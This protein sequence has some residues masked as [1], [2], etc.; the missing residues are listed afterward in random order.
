MDYSITARELLDKLGGEKNIQSLT[1]CMTRLR[2]VL[3]D[4]SNIDDGAVGNIPGVIG[5]NRQGGQYQVIIGNNVAK[6]FREIN[7]IASSSEAADN[8]PKEKQNPVSVAIDFISGCMTQL[9]PAIIAGGMIKVLLII[10]G[11]TLLGL[12]ESTGDTYIILN[13]LGDAPFYFLPVMVAYTAS[14]KLNCNSFLSVTVAAMLLYPDLITLL[15]GDAPTYLFGVIPVTHASYS[16]SIIP[17]MLAVILLKY[18]EIGVDKITPDWSKNFLKPLLI[19]LI[20]GLVTIVALAPLGAIIGTGLQIVINA[21]YNFAPWIAMLLF[22]GAMPF[23]V[24][25]GMHW[26]FVPTALM[27]LADPGFELMLLP[28]MLC[29]NTAQ[30]GATFGVALKT[31]DK[32]MREMAI[33]AGI[34]ALLAGVTEP[35]MYGV[36]L[37]LKK[38]MIAACIASGIAGVITGIVN[39]KAFAFATPCLTAIVQFVAPDGGRN[40]VTAVVIY[41]ISFVLS[42]VLAFILT[43]KGEN[44]QTAGA[45][46]NVQAAEA[47]ENGQIAA[48]TSVR[49][50]VAATNGQSG[51]DVPAGKPL[52]VYN[53]LEGEVIPLAD[54]DD[55][56]FSSEVLG[57][58]YAV[59]PAVG[60]V[61]APF[62]G[63]VETL[64]DTHHALGL[65]SDDGMI[66]LIHVGL[67]TVQLNGKHFT[68]K[69][70]VGDRI[71]IGDVL[72]EFDKAAIEAEGYQTV[73]PVI[74]TNVDD[75]SKMEIGEPG[76]KSFGE[77]M[78]SVEK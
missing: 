51:Q 59:K 50:G 29:S 63:T 62:A 28:A 71:H 65:I 27:A 14:K 52:T 48:D 18:V 47:S 61:K 42:L 8:A 69:V 3:K 30:A 13:A 56:A 36:T 45:G 53:L 54:V 10:F 22:A 60:V 34:S 2:F 21:I 6:C 37:K 25:T 57:K 75:Y 4:D 66:L 9:F 67:D 78:I 31:K 1:H 43:D 68:P 46:R 40:F 17:A 77:E 55:A 74:L 11:P 44:V 73:T 72:L 32:T 24:M 7:Q 41:I 64:M 16:S 15:G 12:M 33:P 38:P 70:K 5:V 76:E 39:L 26:A 58:G 20:T 49:N 23:I 19:V 35:A